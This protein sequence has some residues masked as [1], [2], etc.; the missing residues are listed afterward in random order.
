MTPLEETRFRVK[1]C[2]N[3]TD[4]GYGDITSLRNFVQSVVLSDYLNLLPFMTEL[5]AKPDCD[6]LFSDETVQEMKVEYAELIAARKCAQAYFNQIEAPPQPLRGWDLF[7]ARLER[8]TKIHHECQLRKVVL[9]PCHCGRFTVDDWYQGEQLKVGL[10]AYRKEQS[11]M[12]VDDVD[13]AR[14]IFRHFFNLKESHYVPKTDMYTSKRDDDNFIIT[15]S[16]CTC[17]QHRQ[18]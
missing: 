13:E 5:A 6:P 4:D 10:T 17:S 3:G 18:C 1:C 2:K 12:E 11:T 7:A 9:Y 16:H 15:G 8:V 14:Q